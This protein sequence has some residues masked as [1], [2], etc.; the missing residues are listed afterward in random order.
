MI[1][2]AHKR[3]DSKSMFFYHP[4]NIAEKI[5]NEFT[6]ED[7]LVL[8]LDHTWER[9]REIEWFSI[10][11]NVVK[12]VKQTRP[13]WKV[14]LLTNSWWRC[15][16][17]DINQLGFDDVLYTDFFAYS[18]WNEIIVNGSAATAY[19]WPKHVDKFLFLTGDPQKPQRIRLLWKFIQA[20]LKDQC[21]W[22]LPGIPDDNDLMQSIVHQLLPELN[23][24]QL[25]VFLK[26]CDRNPDDIDFFLE[27]DRF[28]YTSD[29][30]Y[31]VTLYT[32]TCFSV[33]S[34][35]AFNDT[36]FPWI[37]EKTWKAII[38][39]HPFIIAGDT[40]TLGKLQT[41]GFVTFEKFLPY[42]NYDTIQDPEQRLNAILENTKYWLSNIDNNSD[43]IEK[44]VGHNRRKLEQLYQQNLTNIQKFINQH[45]FKLLPNELILTSDRQPA[46]FEDTEPHK[47]SWVSE[48]KFLDFYNSIKDP[49]WPDCPSE[50]DFSSLPQHIQ[51][52]CIEIFG[53]VPQKN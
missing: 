50:K 52:E 2:Y 34:E 7:E 16:S 33:V 51:Q 46:V 21:I 40:N 47:T 8:F 26:A 23:A 29:F 22:S 15:Y 25:K 17:K 11:G 4:D 30:V 38:N 19:K 32:N 28:V 43:E 44:R 49:S 39:N 48:K 3:I 53:Y 41:M 35:T 9:I 27:R 31:D 42:S 45:Q 10:V 5:I 1:K 13:K 36:E 14:F 37:T 20:G 24:E 12:N 18:T 6:Q